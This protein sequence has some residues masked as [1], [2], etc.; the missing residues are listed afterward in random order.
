MSDNVKIILFLITMIS[1]SVAS[2]YMGYKYPEMYMRIPPDHMIM[3]EGTKINI[4]N[5]LPMESA[6]SIGYSQ[7]PPL[8]YADHIKNHGI[9]TGSHH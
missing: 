7:D 6:E 4:Q 2:M 9:L 3:G 8:N 5:S 1:I